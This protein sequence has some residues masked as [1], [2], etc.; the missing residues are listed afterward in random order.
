MNLQKQLGAADLQAQNQGIRNLRDLIV[1]VEGQPTQNVNEIV[2]SFIQQIKDPILKNGL[3]A[4]VRE[5]ARL[6]ANN[7]P[8]GQAGPEEGEE[9]EE[10][11]E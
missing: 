2:V 3:I 5:Q 11:E 1:G 10:D 9:E 8:L 4:Y 6:A 7:K